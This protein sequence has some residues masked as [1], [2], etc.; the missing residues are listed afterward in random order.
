MINENSPNTY[1]NS[2][3]VNQISEVLAGK[4]PDDTKN[5]D[6]KSTV[7]ADASASLDG[8][9]QVNDD[10]LDA[11]NNA[12]DSSEKKVDNQQQTIDDTQDDAPVML[13]D[14]A[15]SLDIDTKDLYDVTIPLGNDKTSTIGELKDT[16]KKYEVILAGQDSFEQNKTRA[17]N[18]LMTTRRQLEQL[19]SIGNQN[20][21]LTPE[22]IDH[23]NQQHLDN[24]AREQTAL[25]KTL[26][27][28][29]DEVTRNNDLNEMAEML[30]GYGFSR[31]ELNHV[32]DHRLM[33]VLYDLTK[34]VNLVKSLQKQSDTPTNIG[35]GK[36]SKSASAH[37]LKQKLSDA[38]TGT[39]QQ[40]VTAISS[41][42]T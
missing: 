3:Q 42:I 17:E 26:P 22:L 9:T 34:R 7:Q 27:E 18:E 30:Q 11:N 41:L 15:E 8:Q 14:L 29:K 25:I 31:A 35:K 5:D 39:Q 36:R 19:I 40:K 21:T 23:I 6:D 10:T 12:D 32:A 33:K 20:G 28:W 16:A 24:M 38:K 4:K 1:A 37:S 13:K 2:E